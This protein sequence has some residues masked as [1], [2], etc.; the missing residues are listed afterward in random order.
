[1]IQYISM[2]LGFALVMYLM[3]KNWNPVIIGIAASALVIFLNGLPYGQTMTD[4]FF[5]SF[6]GM[7]KS[8]FPPIFSGSLLAQT[9]NRSG[10]VVTIADS[11][12]NVMFR[13]KSSGNNAKRYAMAIITMVIVSGVISYCGMNSLVVL[14][15]MYPIALRIMEKAGIPKRFVM[16]ILSGGVYTFA[17]SAPG[18]TETVNILA[19]QAV[20]TPSYAG[21][22]GGFAAVITEVIVMTVILSLLIKKAVANGETFAYG[23]KDFNFSQDEE[24]KKRPN[25][26]ISILPMLVLIVLFNFFSISI[27]SATMIGWL[28]SVVLFWPYMNGKKEL[29]ESCSEG[30]KTA[31][32][33]VSSVGAF[34]GFTAIVQSLPKFQVLMDSIFELKVPAAIILILAISLVAGL[35]GSSSSAVRVGIPIVLDRCR[36][37]GLTDAFIHRVSCFACTTIDTLPWS[38]AIIININLADLKLK[39]AYPPMFASTCVATACGTII[40]SLVMYFFPFLP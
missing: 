31:F 16:G 13:D 6:A 20:G 14:I 29:M 27:F 18:T 17:L 26:I 32:G 8:L 36:A 10:A 11:L 5:T 2:I 35:T 7:F 4:T 33:P 37:A 9:Y 12:T 34:V 1:M 24:S 23:P 39:D 28:L 15:A 21:L 22:V 38:T 3:I 19:M 25:L 40:C 30:A